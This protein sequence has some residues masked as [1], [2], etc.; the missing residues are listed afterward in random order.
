MIKKGFLLASFAIGV[1]A[2]IFAQDTLSFKK[3]R[4][5]NIYVEFL[6][7]SNLI[8][9][10]F[11]SRFTPISPWGYRLGVSYFQGGDS[12]IKASNSNRGLFFPIEVNFLTSGNKHKL[13]LGL[14]SN[15]GIYNEHIYFIEKSKDQYETINF[16]S[17]TTFGYYFFSNIG[18]RYISTKG[19]LFRIGLSPSFSFN[20]KHGVTKEPFIYPYISFGYS[21]YK[22]GECQI[23]IHVFYYISIRILRNLQILAYTSNIYRFSCSIRQRFSATQYLRLPCRQKGRYFR[24]WLAPSCGSTQCCRMS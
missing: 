7:S 21:C 22:I 19:F 2:N 15:L 12:F 3:T 10:S 6:G 5:K 24:W 9:V 4:D 13:E 8:G 20:D 11:D 1:F 16:T 14:G 18:Y 17:N 23:K